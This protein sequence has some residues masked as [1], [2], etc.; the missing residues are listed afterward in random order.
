MSQFQED[1]KKIKE[2]KG[3]H[4]QVDEMTFFDMLGSVPPAF[5]CSR[6]FANGEPY[7]ADKHYCFY[8]KDNV[9]FGFLGT[10]RELKTNCGI[11]ISEKI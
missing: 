4:V 1:I 10:I 6:G 11:I 9:Y 3:G 2:A 5:S 7:I 8:I